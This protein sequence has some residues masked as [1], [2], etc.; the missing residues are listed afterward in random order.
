MRRCSWNAARTRPLPEYPASHGRPARGRRRDRARRRVGGPGCPRAGQD[1]FRLHGD[2][3]ADRRTHRAREFHR[4]QPGR[5]VLRQPRD[6]RQPGPHL[7]DLSGERTRRTQVQ[8]PDHRRGRQERSCRRS[9]QIAG[10]KHVSITRPQQFPRHPG[11]HHDRHGGGAGAVSEPAGAPR[12]PAGS[13]ASPSSAARPN[14]NWWFL[15][16]PSRSIRPAITCWS[17]MTPRRSS[18]GG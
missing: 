12:C 18:C 16:P 1:Q 6:D 9:Y 17:S 5:A 8:T 15:S 7:R 10:R 11:R 13:S 3:F 14:S 2:P 4:G